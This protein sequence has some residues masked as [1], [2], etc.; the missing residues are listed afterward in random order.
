MLLTA[1]LLTLP[2]LAADTRNTDL[3]DTNTHFKLRKYETRAEWEAH[4]AKLRKQ[5]LSATGLFPIPPHATPP[6]AEV[7]GRL[8]RKG[9]SVEKVLLETMPGYFVGGNLYR[10]LDAGKH[11]AVLNAHGHWEYGRLENETLNSAPSFGISMARQGFVV[12]A[13]DMVGYNDTVQTPHDF[14]TPAEKLWQ[15]GPLQLQLWNSIRAMDFVTSLPDVDA[16]NVGMAGPSGGAT[17]TLLLAAIDDRVQFAAPANMVSTTMQ[18]GD[19]CENSPGLRMNTNTVEM[20]A[21][22]APKPL[23]L[24]SATGDW[25]STTPEVEF[26]AVQQI[27]ALYGAAGNV[28]NVHIDAPHNFNQAN[29]EA[30]YRF[31]NKHA[32]KQDTKYAEHGIKMEMLQNMLA[33]H[34]RTLPADAVDYAGVL[35]DWKKLPV[36]VDSDVSRERMRLAMLVEWPA[37]I[38]DSPAGAKLMLVRDQS[39]QQ[40]PAQWIAGTG[41]PV[42]VVHPQGMQTA[43]QDAEVVKLR[44]AHRPLLLI[45][46]FQTGSSVAPRDRTARHFL[47]FNVSDAAG[48][49]QDIATAIAYLQKK[50]NAPVELLG[51]GDA[52]LWTAVAAAISPAPVR[53]IHPPALAFTDEQ[54]LQEFPVPGFQRA[55][56][57]AEVKRL[58]QR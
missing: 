1:L 22:F 12:F 56:G 43:L 23:L 39:G 13:W 5:I 37:E 26:P 21:M 20:A 19:T 48:R 30:V 36:A 18:G 58:L 45:D 57:V 44:A 52:E 25:T 14:G 33:L 15:F 54:L 34:N 28:E 4:K 35:E 2:L 32:R 11:P 49:V 9:Y 53:L 38:A 42:V 6:H 3:P 31:F 17:Q 41:A 46:A 29:R 10:P 51:I 40:V 27:Y 8:E 24:T 7:F 47:A 55:G 16:S 50:S